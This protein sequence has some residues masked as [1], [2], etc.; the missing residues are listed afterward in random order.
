MG[1]DLPWLLQPIQGLKLLGPALVMYH[2]TDPQS[3]S[4][5]RPDGEKFSMAHA[6]HCPTHA[7]KTVDT[8]PHAT[9]LP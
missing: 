2:H 5:Q 7:W 3:D 8:W 1:P 9:L 4:G 6:F